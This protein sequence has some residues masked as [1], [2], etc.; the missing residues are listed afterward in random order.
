MDIN[1]LWLSEDGTIPR[2]LMKDLVH[3]TREGYI[4][5]GN[6]V[7]PTVA[8]MLGVEPKEFKAE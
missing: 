4:L 8:K 1:D 7:D 6:R 2:E 3:P 5:W